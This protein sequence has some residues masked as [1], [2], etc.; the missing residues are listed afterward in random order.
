MKLLSVLFASSLA[1]VSSTAFAQFT[2][3]R[4]VVLQCDGTATTGNSGSLLEYLPATANQA[5]PSFQVALPNN[6]TTSNATS[7]VFGQNSVLNHD[8]S[9]SGDGALV[10]I[11]GYANM[12]AGAVDSVAISAGGATRVVATVKYNGVYARPI[13]TTSLSAAAFRSATSD[14]FGNFWGMGGSG[15]TIYLNTGASLQGTTG[16]ACAVV[17]GSLYYTV[18]ASINTFGGLPTTANPGNSVLI[19]GAS[20]AAGFSIS[21]GDV[22][23]PGARAY[24]CNY[25]DTTGGIMPFTFDG[26]TWTMGNKIFISGGEKPQHIAVDYS[27]ANPVLFVVSGIGS[28]LYAITDTGAGGT[29]VPTVLASVP[30]GKIFRGVALSPKQGVAPSFTVNP[31]NVTD[32]YGATVSFGPVQ[33]DNA[34]PNG[35]TWKKGSVTLVDGGNISG[36]TTAT[37]TIAN[38]TGTDAGTYFAVASNNS[39]STTS[40]G[41]TLALAGSSIT[42]Q[43]ASRTNVAGTTATFHVVSGGAVPLTYQ[44]FQSGNFLNDGGTGSGS[45]ISGSTTDTLTIA[46]VQDGDA[47]NY[48]VTV[49][50]NNSVQ[51][52]STAVLTVVDPPSILQSPSNQNKIAGANASFTVTASGGSLSY[53][54]FKGAALLA[55]GPSGS[56]ATISGATTA[57][58]TITGVQDTDAGSYTCTVT[59]LAGTATSDPATLTVGHAPALTVTLTNTVVAPGSNATFSATATGSPTLTY[60]WKANGTTLNDDGFH[61][62]GATT[63]TLTVM[64]VDQ[65]DAGSYSLTVGNAYGNQTTSASLLLAI[66]QP[67]FDPTPG[68]IVYE[69]FSYP[70]QSYPGFPA[71]GGWVNSWENMVS[72]YNHVTG[73]PAYWFRAGGP[74]CTL[75]GGFFRDYLNHSTS[76]QYPWPGIYCASS[77]QWYWSSAPNNNHLKFGGVHQTNGAAYFSCILQIDQG[78]ALSGGLFDIIAGFTSG[79]SL[80]NGA[81]ADSWNYKLCTQTDGTG[82]DGYYFGVFKGG[83]STINSGSVNGQW[84]SAKHFGRGGIHFIV[85]CYKFGSSTNLVGGS[86][87]NDDVVTLWIDPPLSAYGATELNRPT[88]D[89]GGMV[90][91]WA[92][93]AT[94]TEF[95]LKGTVAPASKRMTDLRIGKSW[96]SVTQPHYPKLEVVNTAP[97]AT[98]SWPTKDSGYILQ[99][100]SSVEGGSWSNIDPPYST[101]GT[102]TT[103]VVTVTPTPAEF[104]RLANPLR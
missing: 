50:D 98:F 26:S 6:G 96:A 37:L 68:L 69:K 27:G 60:T 47:G 91:N 93:N 74:Y 77:N 53:H 102:G 72:T 5:A 80:A 88:P 104:F 49:T 67:E 35:Y 39:G 97:D 85:G 17:N 79:D 38:I 30:S 82:G 3:G 55:N 9:L 41:A 29:V 94:I 10:V 14:G 92:P 83:S 61:I 42:T 20:S 18:T 2:P 78:S 28:K 81:N 32:S 36:A 19:S 8:I 45:V 90:T 33:A 86:V 54:W 13:M 31:S 73:Q 12:T 64:N 34:N 75:E 58:I 22:N 65:P 1:L 46:G 70:V 51:S 99:R 101:D 44:W 76:G 43:L 66:G 63:P 25:N 52:S 40:T 24:I 11:P 59:N 62:F 56:G 7:I 16:R 100:G 71:P 95:G 84:A 48:T 15:G 23:A 57:T 4:V 89:A 103:N 87:T 21:P